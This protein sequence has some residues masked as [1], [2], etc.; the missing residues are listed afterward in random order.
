VDI[1]DLNHDLANPLILSAFN[2]KARRMGIIRKEDANVS[3][4]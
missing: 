3:I 4:V 1:L 2:A